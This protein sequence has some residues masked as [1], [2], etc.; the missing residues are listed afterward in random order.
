MK[1]KKTLSLQSR[2][3]SLERRVGK[4][5]TRVGIMHREMHLRFDAMEKRFDKKFDKLYALIDGFTGR[6]KKQDEEIVTLHLH[7]QRLEKRVAAL[8]SRR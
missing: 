4:L 1:K 3:A 2:V 6:I 5:E 8:E 7:I